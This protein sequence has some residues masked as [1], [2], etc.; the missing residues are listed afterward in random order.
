MIESIADSFQYNF[1]N[2]IKFIVF[3][4]IFFNRRFIV[5]VIIIIINIIIII[6]III[7]FIISKTSLKSIVGE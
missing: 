7:F 3:R 5:F 4:Y 2:R 6:I 1:F